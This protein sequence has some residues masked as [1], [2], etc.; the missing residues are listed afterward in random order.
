[1]CWLVQAHG[2]Y[3]C[4]N[5]PGD[6]PGDGPGNGPG[7]GPENGPGGG[8]GNGPGAGLWKQIP[9]HMGMGMGIPRSQYLRASSKFPD[10]M[11]EA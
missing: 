9:T 2:T 7:D 3:T 4:L 10:G 11:R 8:P 6:G 1:M 5:K